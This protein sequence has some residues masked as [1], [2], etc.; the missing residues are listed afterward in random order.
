MDNIENQAKAE[1]LFKE[2]SP[3][4]SEYSIKRYKQVLEINPNHIP[5]LWN[6]AC[7]Y[8]GDHDHAGSGSWWDEL[9]L[10]DS[11]KAIECFRRILEIDPKYSQAYKRLG[12]HCLRTEKEKAL[13]YFL[14]YLKSNP[15]DYGVIARVG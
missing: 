5:A 9:Y 14:Q 12:R 3:Y 11:E 6:L 7:I 13:G 1:A 2:I 10:E 8:D 15:E 4:I